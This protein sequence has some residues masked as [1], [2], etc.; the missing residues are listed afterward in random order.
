MQLRSRTADYREQSRYPDPAVAY[1]DGNQGLLETDE[2]STSLWEVEPHIHHCNGRHH[3][4]AHTGEAA[5]RR[6]SS[7]GAGVDKGGRQS[8]TYEGLRYSIGYS[9]SN[10]RNDSIGGKC[11]LYQGYGL[12]MGLIIRYAT[13]SNE[14]EDGAV[15]ACE[16]LKSNPTTLLINITHHVYQYEYRGEINKHNINNDQGNAILQKMTFDP[17]VFFNVLLPPIIFHAGYSLKKRHFFRNLGTILTYAFLASHLSALTVQAEGGAHT[18]MSSPPLT[19]TVTAEHAEDGEAPT[20][21]RG[22]GEYLILTCSRR[23]PWKLLPD[24]WS[25][26]PAALPLFSGHWYRS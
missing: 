23:G 21:E 20:L 22:T 14:E 6:G 13:K 5:A 3:V 9:H 7:E 15:Y 11:Q 1:S 17:E 18:N 25:L 12:V 19:L 4:T 16:S 10:Q 26:A 8:K 2:Y 24:R